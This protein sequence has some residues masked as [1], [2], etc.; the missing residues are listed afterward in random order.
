VF[1]DYESGGLNETGWKQLKGDVFKEP[2]FWNLLSVV[3]GTGIQLTIGAI[4]LLVCVFFGFISPEYRGGIITAMIIIYTGLSFLGAYVSARLSKVFDYINWIKIAAIHNFGFPSIIIGIYALLNLLLWC[5]G[6]RGVVPISVV[7]KI[8]CIW[9]FLSWPLSMLGAFVGRISPQ[10]S[11]PIKPNK[12]PTVIPKQHIILNP[13]L[14]NL[15]GGIIPFLYNP[16][17]SYIY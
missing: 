11:I 8:V 7:L 13:M 10:I 15:L 17:Q 16:Y 3:C 6:S 5:K 12:L 4:I 2:P 1:N 9:V 14:T